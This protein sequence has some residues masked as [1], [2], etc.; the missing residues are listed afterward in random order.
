M[1]VHVVVVQVDDAPGDVGAVVAHPFQRGQQVRPDKSGLNAAAALLHPQNVMDAHFLLQI[2]NDLFQ[3]LHPVG[4][5]QI[6]VPE[7]LKGHVHDFLHSPQQNGQ[8]VTGGVGQRQILA[9]Q[10]FGRLY[11]I[12]SV[13]S[14]ALKIAEGFEQHGGLAAVVFADLQGAELDKIGAK[15]ILIMVGFALP[16][17]HGLRKL[18]RVV[19]EGGGGI[20]QGRGGH[21]RHF[22]GDHTAAL[23]RDGG[24]GQQAFVQLTDRFRLLPVGDD[25]AH[26]LF[27]QTCRGQHQGCADDVEHRV[28][29]G[30]AQIRSAF[31]QNGRGEQGIRQHKEGQA[32]NGADDVEHQMHHR[33][34]PG[35]LGG[36][37]AGQQRGDAGADVLTHD[38]GDGCG[39]GHGAGGGQG[40]Q[41]AHGGRRGLDDSGEH[42]AHEN[43]QNGVREH[44]KHLLEF[45]H[46]FQAADRAGHGLHAE[47]QGRKPQKDHAGVLLL[48]VLHEH[49]VHNAHQRKNGGKRAGLQQ[50]DE[51]VPAFNAAEAQYPC[52]DGGTHV[53]AHNDVDGLSQRQKPGVDKADHHDRG[54][55]G[56]LNDARDGKTRQEAQHPVGGELP[57]KHPQ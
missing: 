44:Q 51:D 28:A 18:R 2:V 55:G 32:H 31:S 6:V 8:L 52:G 57:Q 19:L 41:N 24:R 50:P 47:H 30:D 15:D 46:I 34:P 12:Q 37:H 42:R 45:R 53:R 25:P 39:I 5:F 33:S 54:S 38:N 16:L 3:R 27:Q 40:L 48:A 20:P 21:V 26:Q 4:F 11:Q 17:P 29:D 10:F 49:V 14:D 35:V 7:R 56:G 23:Q 13:V 43:A 9:F 1:G 36:T 22:I